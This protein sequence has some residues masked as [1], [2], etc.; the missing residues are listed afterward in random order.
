MTCPSPFKMYPLCVDWSGALRVFVCQTAAFPEECGLWY[1]PAQDYINQSIYFPRDA[2]HKSP[3]IPIKLNNR[4]SVHWKWPRH[5]FCCSFCEKNRSPAIS[6]LFGNT[7]VS[8]CWHIQAM[9]GVSIVAADVDCREINKWRC[10]V[11][12]HG[13]HKLLVKCAVL[14]LYNT[15]ITKWVITSP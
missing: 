3:Q 1:L 14:S 10:L 8:V 5:F 9:S 7:N 15:L 6:A 2:Q 11:S 13:I 4:G 12:T